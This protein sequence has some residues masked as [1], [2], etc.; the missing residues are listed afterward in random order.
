[1]QD[2]RAPVDYKEGVFYGRGANYDRGGNELPKYNNYNRAE[3]PAEQGA[4]YVD[5]SQHQY[6]VS[7]AV[8]KV[9]SVE[10]KAPEPVRSVDLPAVSTPVTPVV[11]APTITNQA[12][13]NPA[14]FI[15]PTITEPKIIEPKSAPN[16][17]STSLMPNFEKQ[18]E[19][20]AGELNMNWQATKDNAEN[21]YDAKMLQA[22]ANL[23]A[24]EEAAK[25]Q[26]QADKEL[27]ATKKQISDG[28][29][30]NPSKIN[31]SATKILAPTPLL[32]V[33][34]PLKPVEPS[35]PANPAASNQSIAGEKFI[36]PL[37]GKLLKDY[38]TDAS[39]GLVI[40]GRSGEPVRAS[41]SGVVVHIG[42]KVKSFGNMII[43]QHPDGYVTTY[44]HLSD[45]AVSENDNVVGGQLIGFVGKTGDAE[46]P[47]LHFAVRHNTQPIDPAKKLSP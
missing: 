18:A 35:K 43:V 30:L 46:Q 14:P 26:H 1:M 37:K 47:Q 44:S 25:L 33:I 5:D 2:A 28:L 11:V 22:E 32:P 9:E 42:T 38:N 36:W 7:A 20:K 12:I 10:L 27:I 3:L 8:D 34:A 19:A 17:N 45:M 16:N 31:P 40:A 4:K 39:K 41:A 13:T 6:G 23:A 29:H 21:K 24:Q 15:E